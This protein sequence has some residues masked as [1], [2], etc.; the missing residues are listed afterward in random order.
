[1]PNNKHEISIYDPT[2]W[3]YVVVVM[4]CGAFSAST[5]Y[6]CHLGGRNFFHY[7][8]I[9]STALAI[10][11]MLSLNSFRKKLDLTGNKA[12]KNLDKIKSIYYLWR[13]VW[14]LVSLFIY[15]QVSGIGPMPLN[16]AFKVSAL[17]C[18]YLIVTATIGHLVDA[19]LKRYIK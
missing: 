3:S 2:L 19:G 15:W 10:I 5:L 4:M 13:S 17:F 8:N 7:T 9:V 12:Q 14:A 16:Q 18:V 6:M 1:M 11:I